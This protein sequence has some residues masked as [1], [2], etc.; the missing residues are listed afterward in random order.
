MSL[1]TSVEMARVIGNPFSSRSNPADP[2][3]AQIRKGREELVCSNLSPWINYGQVSFQRLA[4]TPVPHKSSSIIITNILL[5][6]TIDNDL[7][8]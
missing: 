2:G 6:L 1:I 8:P 4:M 3:T 7:E 5:S